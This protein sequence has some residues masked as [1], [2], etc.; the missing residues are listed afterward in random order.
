MT[1]TSLVE[2]CH[3]LN[4]TPTRSMY[5]DMEEVTSSIALASNTS[6]ENLLRRELL[7]RQKTI[8]SDMVNHASHAILPQ[9]L[10]HT[11]WI[12]QAA[13]DSMLATALTE[14][15]YEGIRHHKLQAAVCQTVYDAHILAHQNEEL[16]A[17]LC[18]VAKKDVGLVFK[19]KRV[20]INIAD[21]KNDGLELYCGTVVSFDAA[22]VT[23]RMDDGDKETVANKFGWPGLVGS[24]FG[25]KRK[26]EL[27]ATK[28]GAFITRKERESL[29]RLADIKIP[30]K[31]K[32]CVGD[33]VAVNFG[34]VEEPEVFIGTINKITPKKLAVL[35]DD[36]EDANI[37]KKLSVTGLLG[38]V[39]NLTVRIAKPLQSDE[40]RK[41][42]MDQ[43]IIFKLLKSVNKTVNVKAVQVKK[44]S[45]KVVKISQLPA[46]PE[47]K[48]QRDRLMQR[49]TVKKINI[50]KMPTPS[51][52]DDDL[53]DDDSV[54]TFN[55]IMDILNKS[56]H[57][58]KG[59]KKYNPGVR[60]SS[61]NTPLHQYFSPEMYD[62]TKSWFFKHYKQVRK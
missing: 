37:D 16:F 30:H 8:K 46:D 10:A 4:L 15:Q 31:E 57:G 7:I 36:G 35:F 58:K 61:D 42:V 32:Y 18:A 33:R 2:L 60:P 54:D 1:N 55:S 48:K 59:V 14:R 45:N 39:N 52:D 5:E 28:I 44:P 43:N 22:T 20:V 29:E 41:Y 40:I 24:Y 3:S 56:A 17:E 19:G 12:D 13:V 49:P 50:H 51:Q 34:D 62:P 21:D 47:V 38:F 11:K 25:P 6:H 27:D 26:S 53:L 9:V 23:V